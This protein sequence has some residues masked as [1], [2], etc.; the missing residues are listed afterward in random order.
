[1]GGFIRVVV[2][3]RL[4]HGTQRTKTSIGIVKNAEPSPL[5]ILSKRVEVEDHKDEIENLPERSTKRWTALKN[6]LKP[7]R[8]LSVMFRNEP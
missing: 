5:P 2:C 6:H 7:K 4:F 8:C 3:H 1:M